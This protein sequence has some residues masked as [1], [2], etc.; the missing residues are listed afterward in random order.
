VRYA[1]GDRI[2]Q[3]QYGTGTVRNVDEYHTVIDFDEHGLRRFS[4]PMV[5]L[6]RSDTVEP[7]RPA[8]RP[9]AKKAAKTA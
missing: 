5:K 4:T 2:L 8:K 7:G 9:R 1:I 6:E 3:P